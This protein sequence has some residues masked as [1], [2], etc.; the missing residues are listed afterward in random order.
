MGELEDKL[1]SIL[2]SPAEME[3]IMGIA[4]SL[5]QSSF[6]ESKQRKE[7]TSKSE[8]TD[9]SDLFG[10]LDPKMLT[11]MTRLMTSMNNNSNDKTAVLNTIKPYLKK[12]RQKK[13]DEAANLARMAKLARLAFS[14]FSGGEQDV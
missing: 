8:Q 6:D 2:S 10:S 1:N 3:K 11:M 7:T 4:R 13:L 12:E 14:E 5:S 9:S